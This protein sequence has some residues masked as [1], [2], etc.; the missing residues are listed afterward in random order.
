MIQDG[1]GGGLRSLIMALLVEFFI[2]FLYNRSTTNRFVK[3]L[4]NDRRFS[5]FKN[6]RH[7][8]LSLNILGKS[9]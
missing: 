5:V 1:T 3:F 8:C 7:L 9:I 2:G 4:T 6:R